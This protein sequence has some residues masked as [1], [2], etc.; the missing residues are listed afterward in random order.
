MKDQLDYVYG[1]TSI[2]LHLPA[3]QLINEHFCPF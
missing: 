2:Y 1:K 3:L